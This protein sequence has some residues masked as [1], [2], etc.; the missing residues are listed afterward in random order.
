[1]EGHKLVFPST[2]TTLFASMESSTHNRA[3]QSLLWHWSWSLTDRSRHV[4]QSLWTSANNNNTFYHTFSRFSNQKK[5]LSTIVTK[6]FWFIKRILKYI[7]IASINW[8]M[9]SDI[10][11][12]KNISWRF[13]LSSHR[14]KLSF[15]NI[16]DRRSCRKQKGI[17]KNNSNNNDINQKKSW[18][19]MQQL[20]LAVFVLREN[21]YGR[22]EREAKELSGPAI[23]IFL[24]LTFSL[25]LRLSHCPHIRALQ[26]WRFEIH[27][28][29]IIH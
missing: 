11:H 22:E 23:A 25:S 29:A 8:E 2:E 10:I 18:R 28:L 6:S 9:Q 26:G 17:Q 13:C 21:E 12:W 15:Q 27:P 1:M 19:S 4:S 20:W 3:L 7:L 5:H 14:K 16:C 24:P